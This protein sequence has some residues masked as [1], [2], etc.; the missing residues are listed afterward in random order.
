MAKKIKKIIEEVNK[1]VEFA[2][3]LENDEQEWVKKSKNVKTI[4]RIPG[5]ASLRRYYRIKDH[6]GFS[7]ILMKTAPFEQE[8]SSRYFLDVQGLLK[9]N[10]ISVPEVYEFN[11]HLGTILLED[12]G[13]E[14]LLHKLVQV[15]S[16]EEEKDRFKSVIN[17]LIEMQ[18][19][20]TASEELKS[21][22]ASHVFF[23]YEKFNW[24]VQYTYENF[25][26]HYLKRPL[27]ARDKKIMSEYFERICRKLSSLEN[28][29]VHR[30]FHSRNI[31]VKNNSNYFIDFQDARLGCS[32]YDLASLL[33]DSYYQLSD[34][35]LAEL[36]VYYYDH[37]FEGKINKP[38]RDEFIENFD[39]MSIQRNFKAIGSFSSFANKRGDYRYV[40]YIGN[41]FENIRKTLLNY[42][43]HNKFKEVLS[44]YYYF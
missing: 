21:S 42:P 44:Y 27:Q 11:A 2:M 24:E 7:Y 16:V 9:F 25:F 32:Y 10:N 35:S 18:N 31:M 39:E 33:K 3:D 28:V 37:Y 4:Q 15:Q 22:H 1:V 40:K 29:F 20:V 12:L 30:D 14:S 38:S 43:Q 5:D 13:E 34:A 6:E 36:L 19:K 8:L 41:T 23:D 26:D 17:Q